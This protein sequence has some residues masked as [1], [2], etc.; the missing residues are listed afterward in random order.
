MAQEASREQE[1]P[2]GPEDRTAAGAVIAADGA[3]DAS[4][5][6][7]DAIER[8]T[9]ENDDPTVAQALEEAATHADTAATRVGWLRN[10]IRRLFG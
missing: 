7:L 10:T 6:T 2:A 5:R 4:E 8:A 1:T 3:V 9:E